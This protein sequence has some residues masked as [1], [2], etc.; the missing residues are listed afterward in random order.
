MAAETFIVFYLQL[1]NRSG[2][3]ANPFSPGSRVCRFSTV[4]PGCRNRSITML[5]RRHNK[6]TL[7]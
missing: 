2:R 5:A 4:L 6:P 1:R 3:K 7:E